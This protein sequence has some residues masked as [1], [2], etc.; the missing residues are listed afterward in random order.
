MLSRN[1]EWNTSGKEEEERGHRK[2]K[3]KGRNEVEEEKGN[4]QAATV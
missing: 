3:R 1:R 2:K 4:F